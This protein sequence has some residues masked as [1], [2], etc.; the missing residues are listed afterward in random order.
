MTRARPGSSTL[1]VINFDEWGGFFDHVPPPAG[2]DVDPKYR[3]SAAS[4]CRACSSPRSRGAATSRTAC[5]TT[6]RS[7]KLIEWRWGLEPLSVRDA[8]ANNLATALDFSRPVLSAP[9]IV[10]PRVVGAACPA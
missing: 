2:P 6:P 7:C 9:A 8:Q 3:S 5:T 4:A 1:L 10:A